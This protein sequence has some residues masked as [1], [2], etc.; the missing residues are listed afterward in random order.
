MVLMSSR[1]CL[2]L[3]QALINL[4]DNAI[5]YAPVG[6]QINVEVSQGLQDLLVEVTD[7]GPGIPESL[8]H[9]IFDRFWRGAPDQ[10]T[11]TAGAGLGLALAKWA[12]E[13]NLGE[14]S[15]ERSTQGGQRVSDHDAKG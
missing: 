14:L 7:A 8:Q 4:V 13:A 15:Y 10:S 6:G 2:V 1:H 5:K 9:R 11:G 12:V 3:R